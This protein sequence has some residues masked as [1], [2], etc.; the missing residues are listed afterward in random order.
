MKNLEYAVIILNY[1]TFNDSLVAINSVITHSTTD[2]YRIV[3]VDGNSSNYQDRE[4]I[5]SL[6]KDKVET[7]ILN[8][9]K[10]YAYGNNRGVEYIT[11]RYNVKHLVIMNPDVYLTEKGCI[12]YLIKNIKENRE[13]NVIGAQPL[14]WTGETLNPWNQINIRKVYNWFD[15]LIESFHLFKILFK[16]RYYRNVYINDMPY[17][18]EI[19]YEVPA[20]SFFII[21]T[22]EFL[23]VNMF[24]ERTFLYEEEMILGHKIKQK[25][26]CFIFVPSVSVRH[27]QGKST[28]SHNK[29]TKF[30]FE[31]MLKSKR[32]YMKEYLNVNSIQEQ[33][34]IFFEWLNYGLKSVRDLFRS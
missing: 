3:L 26:K 8:E 17:K 28:G 14:V 23:Q 29:I 2:N 30:A 12:E 16:K 21:N 32:L 13:N 31:H 24:D 22:N 9:N 11:S 25:G 1:N 5:K 4:K 33:I 27:E 7:L 15:C 34:I 18:N 19:L 10:G 6:K 20:G